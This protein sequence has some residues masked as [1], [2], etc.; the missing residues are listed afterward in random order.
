MIPCQKIQLKLG[1]SPHNWN[2]HA[3]SSFQP[4]GKTAHSKTI[5]FKLT[6]LMEFGWNWSSDTIRLSKTGFEQKQTFDGRSG[7]PPSDCGLAATDNKQAIHPCSFHGFLLW[8]HYLQTG[9]AKV[10][11]TNCQCAIAA[12]FTC[13]IYPFYF[14]K[15]CSLWLGRL[16]VE[17]AYKKNV[18]K[19]ILATSLGNVTKGMLSSTSLTHPLTH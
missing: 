4:L 9:V 17:R 14:P 12:G 1:D 19:T 11:L 3:R 10:H 13:R 7:P 15:T 8:K 6:K 2:W 16:L 5:R 18:V